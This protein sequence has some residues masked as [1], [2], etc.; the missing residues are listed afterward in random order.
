MTKTKLNTALIKQAVLAKQANRRQATSATKTRGLVAGGGKK[1]W[2]QKG[3]GRARAGSNR[4]PLWRS[5]GITF[6]PSANRQYKQQLPK[7]MA[8]AAFAELLKH[9]QQINKAV[10]GGLI[11]LKTPKTKEAMALLA[12]HNLTGKSV[13]FVTEKI[14]PELV[15]ACQNIPGVSVITQDQL[16]INDL[17]SQKTLVMEAAVFQHYFPATKASKPTDK[18]ESKS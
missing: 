11:S 12:K 1:P 18:K 16:S 3:T 10:D 5:G 15:L 2:K 13:I 4:S 17:A 7:K 8:K 9:L 6:G 14:Q